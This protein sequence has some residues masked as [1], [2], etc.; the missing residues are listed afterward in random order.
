MSTPT[1]DPSQTLDMTAAALFAGPGEMRAR[2]RAFDWAATSLGPV[3]AWPTALQALVGVVL[4][5]RQPMILWWGPELVQLYNDA[6][7][8]SLSADRHAAALG[9]HA[10]EFWHDAWPIVG[11]EIEAMLAGGPATWH[12]DRLVPIVREGRLE[13]VYWTYG[14]TPIRDAGSV[15][16]V[17]I[18]TLDTSARVR[19]RSA[20]ETELE[21]A[22]QQLQD[23]AAELEVTNEELQASAAELEATNEELQATA[24][25]LTERTAQAEDA[26]A[27]L[28]DSE[29]Q[30]RTMLDAM[31]MLAWT[32][33]ADGSIE[34]YNAGWYAYTGTTPEEM[35]GWGWQRVHDPAVL[36]RVLE[37][38]R[39][40]IATGEPFEMTFPLR[41][42]D[43]RFRAFLTRVT[44]VRDGEGDVVRWFGTNTDVEAEHAAREA[45]EHA[46]RAKTDFMATMSHELRTPLNAIAGYAELLEIGIHGPMTDPQ[47][48]AISRIQRSQRHLLGLINDVLNF[49]KLEVGRV[50]YAIRDVAVCDVVDELDPL[51]APQLAAKALT[52]DRTRCTERCVVRADA[53][54]LQQILL[55]VLSNAIK[56]TAPAG[57]ITLRCREQGP[58]LA[59]AI[60]DTGIGI[61]PERWDDIFEP[62]V[63]IDRRLNTPHEGTGLGLAISRDLARGMG[64]DLTVESTPGVGSTFTLTLPRAHGAA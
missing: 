5:S 1:Q 32:A 8:P 42:A 10:R 53:D 31:P 20:R 51:V 9:A 48:T 45:A 34:W 6:Y 49:A 17:L 58:H 59:V 37:R 61:A 33:G 18:T 24:A 56:F 41:G 50:E 39:A 47:R 7:R 60:E 38:W 28:A 36:P 63:Q 4:A 21:L 44:P 26:A 64:G 3:E 43:G 12:E 54:K 62:F 11:P 15:A 55:N 40:S 27:A 16:G 35:A 14:Y 57:A 30:W 46:N 2:C 52:Y 22:N 29:R 19:A 13:D 23:Q 25:A